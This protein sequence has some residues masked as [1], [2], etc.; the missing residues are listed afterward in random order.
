MYWN[1]GFSHTIFPQ[2]AH[3]TLLLQCSV[4][5]MD[6]NVCILHSAQEIV[7]LLYCAG[8]CTAVDHNACR[9]Q[10]YLQVIWY[11]H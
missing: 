9:G 3:A 4:D 7:N 6:F 5:L 11:C 2:K 8:C 1:G 10:G